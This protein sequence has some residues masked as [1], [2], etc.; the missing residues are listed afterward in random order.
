MFNAVTINTG[1]VPTPPQH[2]P[3]TDMQHPESVR[4][5]GNLN[6]SLFSHKKK[7][8][9]MFSFARSIKKKISASQKKGQK[10]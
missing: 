1:T 7:N 3:Q 10:G 8:L 9:K 5:P 4:N 6:T 2:A